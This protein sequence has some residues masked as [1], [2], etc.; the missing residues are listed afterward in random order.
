VYWSR[1]NPYAGHL[2]VDEVEEATRCL[3]NAKRP[4]VAASCL[5]SAYH[6][7]KD[8]DWILVADVVD[9][10]ST[11][12]KA[13]SDAGLNA[14]FVWELCELVKYLQNHPAANHD[15]LVR[16]EYRFLLRICQ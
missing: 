4:I 3:L 7:K 12:D 6:E 1:V 13:E 8:F 9:A 10:A 14:Q 15:R 11:I 2:P 5:F 16:I